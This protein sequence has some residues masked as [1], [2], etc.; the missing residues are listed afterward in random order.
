[1]KTSVRVLF[2]SL[3]L[4]FFYLV[5]VF[6]FEQYLQSATY[7]S[8]PYYFSRSVRLQFIQKQIDILNAGNYFRDPQGVSLFQQRAALDDIGVQLGLADLALL[9]KKI[10]QSTVFSMHDYFDL[11]YLMTSVLV[12]LLFLP[13]VP[14]R[15]SIVALLTLMLVQF[16]GNLEWGIHLYWPPPLTVL[17]V[18]VLLCSL[19]RTCTSDRIRVSHVIQTGMQAFYISVLGL[20][21]SEARIFGQALFFSLFLIL[22]LAILMIAFSQK[23]RSS[24]LDSIARP[25]AFISIVSAL[26][27]VHVFRLLVVAGGVFAFSALFFCGFL[28]LN[29]ALIDRIDAK[30]V[31]AKAPEG[32]SQ[33]HIFWHPVLIGMGAT[34]VQRTMTTWNHENITWHDA[35][36]YNQVWT[37]NPEAS[38]SSSADAQ[39]NLTETMKNLYLGILQHNPMDLFVSYYTKVVALFKNS[40]VGLFL[41]VL[42]FLYSILR[43]RR[44]PFALHILL[45][46]QFAIAFLFAAI[47]ASPIIASAYPDGNLL[48]ADT[49]YIS[50]YYRE[51]Y[52]TACGSYYWISYLH[53]YWA[54]LFAYPLLTLTFQSLL[55]GYRQFSDV[56][57]SHERFYQTLM[58]R[59][60]LFFA[61]SCLSLFSIA[62][63]W[64][65]V[66]QARIRALQHELLES[67]G[68]T[69]SALQGLYHA[70]VVRTINGLPEKVKDTAL[71]SFCA[72][73]W[74]IPASL[75]QYSGDSANLV[76]KGAKWVDEYLFLVVNVR[77]QLKGSQ[78]I[79][80]NV[81]NP[82][83]GMNAMLLLP[84]NLRGGNW[85]FS[86]RVGNKS[87]R[88]TLYEPVETTEYSRSLTTRPL[89]S[90]INLSLVGQLLKQVENLKD[91]FDLYRFKQIIGNPVAISEIRP[92]YQK[93][94]AEIL[95]QQSPFKRSLFQGIEL[96]DF[97]WERISPK[98]TNGTA[99]FQGSF[100]LRMTEQPNLTQYQQMGLALNFAADEKYRD[101]FTTAG[102]KST[103]L[104]F[105]LPILPFK[106]WKKGDYDLL[107][108]IYIV[109]DVPYTL[110]VF[111]S[112]DGKMIHPPVDLGQH[113]NPTR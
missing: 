105:A 72:S 75:S 30:T 25:R 71:D 17:L 35:T 2:A 28:S 68:Q 92:V 99:T 16:S 85:L 65:G 67:N 39:K 79:P 90:V 60:L 36:S 14:L 40:A 109:P 15:I 81:H 54:F 69:V 82:N 47:I 97:K 76:L 56:F 111:L 61:F 64:L 70:D 66:K 112:G 106:S 88:V 113:S 59:I 9:K 63:I 23:G 34:L 32:F 48:S 7:S 104:S 96:V 103:N 98:Q 55:P 52:A 8:A 58:R 86:V 5:H 110:K 83:L 57:R 1:L 4:V 21:R 27:R 78:I 62:S 11:Q 42:V 51:T 102:F 101:S 93:K 6:S 31:Q 73:S 24:F 29:V 84:Q 38:Y 37:V 43:F 18:F 50:F 80:L 74:G 12:V 91:P 26:W 87:N 45:V 49:D 22:S 107:K 20:C 41:C 95:S 53:S 46:S 77:K 89:A 3:G 100:L 94:E 108:R 33:G 19:I 10:F 13:V 44:D